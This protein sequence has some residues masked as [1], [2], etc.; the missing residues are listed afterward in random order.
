MTRVHI[1]P[2]APARLVSEGGILS[3]KIDQELESSL[4]SVLMQ[5]FG[6]KFIVNKWKSRK[7]EF[8]TDNADIPKMDVLEATVNVATSLELRLLK[9]TQKSL[10]KQVSL[11]S[12]PGD[13]LPH[14]SEALDAGKPIPPG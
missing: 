10:Q 11:G 9:S 14:M 13:V 4:K 5:R 3:Q 2:T 1:K 8:Y 6:Q 7:F 12:T